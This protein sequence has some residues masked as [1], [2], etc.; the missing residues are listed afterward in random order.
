MIKKISYFYEQYILG[1]PA[2][3]L[4][5]LSIILA[6][7]L[8]N[9][10]N[11]KLDA[12]ADT[13]I[14]DDDE[15]LKL[16][17]EI[18]DR[19]E[20]NDF[21][22][23]TVTDKNEDIFANETLDYIHN[24]TLE[25]EEFSSVQS[26]TAI[27][28]IPL[29]SSSKKPLTELINNIPNIFSKDIDPE[30][31]Q[32]EILTSPIYKDLVI[33]QDAKTTAM[34]VTLKKNVAL[35]EALIK[36][37]LY[38]KKFV[39]DAT[40]ETQ[41]LLS[42]QEYNNISE[43]QKKKI[44]DLIKDIR[45]VQEKYTSDRYEIRLGGIPMI[46]DDMVTFI[47]NDL[48]NFGL[49]VLIF[50]LATLVIIFRKLIWV[51]T[52]VINCIYSVLF[53]IGLLGYLDWKVTVISS[54]FIS[55][56]LI[57]TL[58]M[59]I[60][61]IVRYR[62]IYTSSNQGKR[63]SLFQTT[64]KMIW[65]CLYTALTT[66]VAFASLIFSDIKPV[67]D[68]GY[69]MVLGLTTLFLTSFFLLPCLIM[70][71]SNRKNSIVH[72]NQK[73]LFVT[74]FLGKATISSGKSIYVIFTLVTLITVYG[75]S[76][77]K[78]ENS[79]INYFRSDTEI[80]KGMQLIDNE[81]GGT[82]PM[83][84]I[85]K[86]NDE[87]LTSEDDEFGDLLG[88][89]DEPVES[90][91]FTTDKINKIKYVHDYLDKNYYIGKV[92]SFASSIRVAEIVNDDK[93]LNSLEM[94]LLYKKLPDE[95]KDIAVTPYLSIDDN[96]ARINIRI[97]DSNPDLRRAD[98]IDKIQNDLNQDPYL[99]SEKITLTGILLLYNNMLQ[100][101]FDSQIKSLGFVM[102][103]IATMFLILFKSIALMV[104]GIVPN[105]IS[106]L[107]VLGIMGIVKLPLDMMT[108][109]IAA[110][111]VGIAVDN[112]IHYIYRFKEELKICDDYEQTILIC[113]STI[114][115][116]IFFTGITVIFGFSILI[117]SNFIPTIIFGVLTGF[118]MFVA[119]IAVLTL[120]PRMLISFKP[121]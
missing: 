58:S 78:V 84:I 116:A 93:E 56:M 70:I 27:T 44:S 7:S 32:Q 76:L 81:L 55:L 112:S 87:K 17:R 5:L 80:Y 106:A 88:D 105:L 73:K 75:L 31:A 25:I 9:I 30:L 18:S 66:I 92:L 77:L 45:K 24:L 20:S 104:I 8:S 110:I 121:I 46:T 65:P 91:W 51:M 16:F 83:D 74:D 28:N 109:T 115:K 21:L 3:V 86:F 12:S 59:N 4:A 94:S 68:F 102:L 69:M 1:Y 35:K 99:K 39:Q 79:F 62:Q 53:M 49:G 23:L 119:L 36:R 85:I 98:L 15:D 72:E 100:S 111:T 96:E 50:I 103:I 13:L 113:H 61:I 48:I 19:Y 114:G 60:H 63:I 37:E 107:L 38:Y 117:L 6:V 40:F 120:L 2:L 90:N 11:F 67:M 118:A 29:V 52:P 95:V 33:S 42:K 64:Q 47:K 82:T 41:Y 101:L 22:I 71:F 43:T 14:L 89:E 54:N 57:L 108:I 34:Q 26:V 97:L 10:N